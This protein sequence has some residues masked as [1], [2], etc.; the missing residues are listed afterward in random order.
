MDYVLH[1]LFPVVPER[2][3]AIRVRSDAVWRPVISDAPG[4]EIE[5]WTPIFGPYTDSFAYYMEHGTQPP[6]HLPSLLTNGILE[7][8]RHSPL[9]NKQ[10]QQQRAPGKPLAHISYLCLLSRM[11]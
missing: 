3:N 1:L 2:F 5:E 11:Y 4:P 9:T 6:N 8:S 10:S 7:G